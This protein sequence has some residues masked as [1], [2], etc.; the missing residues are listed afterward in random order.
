MKPKFLFFPLLFCLGLLALVSVSSCGRD[1]VISGSSSNDISGSSVISEA[2]LVGT[3]NVTHRKGYYIE[4]NVKYEYND[5]V[6]GVYTITFT[7]NHIWSTLEKRDTSDLGKRDTSE[8]KNSGTWILSGNELTCTYSD[9]RVDKGIIKINDSTM[10]MVS[11][12]RT[13]YNNVLFTKK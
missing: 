5:S 8:K 7:K 6:S 2:S 13:F 12:G 4:K 10:V 3:W 11:S 1:D 9:K